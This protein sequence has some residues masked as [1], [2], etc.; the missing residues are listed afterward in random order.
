MTIK[1]SNFID[2]F[3]EVFVDDFSIFGSS[4]DVRLAN[5]SSTFKKEVNLILSWLKSHFM[6]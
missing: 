5:L 1:F 4:F 6:A 3:M 2:N